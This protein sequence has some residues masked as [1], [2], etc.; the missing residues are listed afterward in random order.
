MIK[1]AFKNSKILSVFTI[2]LLVLTIFSNVASS[3]MAKNEEK[4]TYDKNEFIIELFDNPVFTYFNSIKIEGKSVFSSSSE[5]LLKNKIES[6]RRSILNSHEKVVDSILSLADEKDR[7]TIVVS[8]EYTCIL[9]GFCIK[10]IP[11]S[12]V[13]KIKNLPIVKNVYPNYRFS[14]CLDKSI[15]LIK[16]SDAWN[17]KDK[18]GINITGQG[19]DVAI[20]DTGIDY[21]HPDLVDSYKG[22]YDFAN[23][24]NDPMDDAGHGTHCAGI[25]SGDGI[26]SNYEYIGVAPNANL[27][28]FKVLDSQGSGDLDSYIAGL[29]AAADPND[30]GN[31]SDHVDIISISFGTDQSGS[32]D[33][34]VSLKA[35]E[36][37]DMGIV[38]VVAAGNNGPESNSITSPG[39]SLKAITVG[40]IDKNSQISTTSSRGPVELNDSYYIKPDVVAPG[41]GIKSTYPGGGYTIMSGTSMATPHVAGAAALLL[42]ANPHLIPAEVKQILKDSSVD[43]G[44]SGEDNIYGSGRIN[45]LNA[46]NPPIAFLNISSR[47]PHGLV[48]IVGSAMNSSG[49]PNEFINYSLYYSYES[50]WIK[51]FENDEEV[52]NGILCSWNTSTLTSGFYELKL[53][54]RC[55]NQ[56]NVIVKGVIIGYTN[57]PFVVSFPKIVN[58][59]S[60]FQVKIT[61][62]NGTPVKAFVFFFSSFSLPRIKYGSDIDF[63][64]PSIH[65]SLPESKKGKIIAIRFLKREILTK[66]ITILNN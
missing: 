13:D 24:D 40:S 35:D 64:V 12:L 19:I 51:I 30:D 7:A 44:D 52:D 28:A 54:V 61:D 60:I 46:L 15:P 42:Q 2:S 9:N 3:L 20:L 43:L 34:V 33:D 62:F 41:V 14:V 25:I 29:E 32:P 53:E 66:E 6:Y 38:V 55:I 5:S 37:V 18:F 8:R 16:A 65:S 22:G 11:L 47:I 45:V 56:T 10:N 48:D 57:E 58:E 1:A 49:D 59:S 27:Y 23:D 39:C 4:I 26:S 21:T 17:I 50:S 31:P 36:M 63:K